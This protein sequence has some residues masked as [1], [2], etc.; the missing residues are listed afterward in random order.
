M[1]LPIVAG[2]EVNTPTSGVQM[3]SGAFREA[4]LAPGKVAAAIGQNVGG[5]FEDVSQKIQ[6]NQ[7]ADQI[8]KASLAMMKTKDDF[9]ANLAKMPDPGT[10]VPA[11]N[12]QVDQVRRQTL[13]DPR[14]GPDVK[15]ALT[16]KFDVWEAATKSEIRGAALLKGAQDTRDN[17]TAAATYAA[18]HGR[19][20]EAMNITQGMVEANAMS[21]A[22]ANKFS[23]RFPSIA[24]QAQCDNAISTK[25]IKAPDLI[26]PFKDTIEPDVFVGVEA[27]A[28]AARNAK[29][30][31]NLNDL[32]QDMDN[33]PDGTIDPEVLAESVEAGEITERGANGLIARMKRQNI[34]EDNNEGA[35]ILSEIVDHDFVTDKTPEDTKNDF[36]ER[37]NGV[38]NLGLRARLT[39]RLQNKMEAAKKKGESEERPVIADQL[40][41]MKQDFTEGSAFVPMTEGKPAEKGSWFFGMGAKDAE[42]SKH[43]PGG[44]K[45]IE[46]LSDDEFH[47]AFGEKATRESVLEAARLNYASK[48]KQFL[49]WAHD[50]KNKDATP[51]EAAEERQRLERPD[52]MAAAKSTVH[53][54]VP[55][56]VTTQEDFDALPSGAAF[57]WNGR[58]GTKN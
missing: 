36:T 9:T 14:A 4:A 18:M 52:A 19:L 28:R 55:T 53:K 47:D 40:A 16:E 8:F 48:Q 56:A 21:Q 51:A 12:E 29:Q 31:E 54:N 41:Y 1:A 11:W 46:K 38:S 49:D 45:A 2:S 32:A 27:K 22:Q 50:P 39:Q 5:L 6:A 44:M 37:I 25:P 33:S 13:D 10:W 24:A 7:N 3:N 17:G 15:R 30:A 26:Q 23:S 42:P 20:E 34:T 57:I 58:I 43:I 35:L